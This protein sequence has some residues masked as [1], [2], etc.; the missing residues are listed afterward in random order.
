M[1]ASRAPRLDFPRSASPDRARTRER[2]LDAAEDLFSD[3][4]YRATSVR[5]ITSRAACNLASVN[6]HFG[7]KLNLYRQMFHRRLSAVRERRIANI[8]KIQRRAAPPEDL[9]DFLRSFTDAFLEPHLDG[10]R[11][12]VLMRLI[13]HEVADPHLPPE[14]F[15]EEMLEPVLEATTRSVTRVCPGL[16]AREARRCVLSLIAQLVQV[17]QMRQMPA[18]AGHAGERDFALPRI[19]DHIVRFSAAGMRACGQ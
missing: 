11:G 17:V 4:G 18:P 6:Y 14:T 8:R 2:L 13:A 19:I 5:H 12:R 1:S 15:R 16:K 10:M 7:G 9:E 3:R